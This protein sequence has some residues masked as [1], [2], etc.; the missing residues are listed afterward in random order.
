[1][2]SV[3]S[4]IR[5][6]VKPILY[7]L[8][9]RKGYVY[10][11][12]LGKLQDIKKRLVEEKEMVLL[13]EFLKSGSVAIDIGA[14]FAYYT[15]RLSRIVGSAGKVFAFEPI[16]FTHTVCAKIVRTLRLKNTELFM[17]GVGEKNETLIFH[18]PTVEFGGVSAGL[19][20][21]GTRENPA[22]GREK[23]YNFSTHEAVSCDV[24]SIDDFLLP[25]LKSLD[26]VKI[27]IEGA[28]F[29]A[30]KGMKQTLLKFRP[31]I[32][33]E[34][35]PYFLNGFRI[36]EKDLLDF[37]RADLGYEIFHYDPQLRKLRRLTSALWDSNYILIHAT[38]THQFGNII[39]DEIALTHS[40]A[41]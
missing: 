38:R 39:Y 41:S 11:Q 40:K 26:F 30:L 32:L 7:R 21:L 29:F 23:F 20:H 37:I 31:S 12:Y 5:K 17:K 9:G 18:V 1:M 22:E 15:E 4:P 36:Q 10:V 24:V 25:K 6:F 28:E 34:I 13:S 19:A 3:D 33:I 14:N 2:A 8:L 35:Q 27:D 16:P